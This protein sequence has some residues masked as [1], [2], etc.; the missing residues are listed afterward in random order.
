MGPSAVPSSLHRAH[1]A[2][3]LTSP[4]ARRRLPH[5]AAPQAGSARDDQQ[6]RLGVRPTLSRCPSNGVADPLPPSPSAGDERVRPSLSLPPARSLHYELRLT[7]SPR[8]RPLRQPAAEPV[9][10]DRPALTAA[11]AASRSTLC[12]SF[13]SD[14]FSRYLSA[15]LRQSLVVYSSIP[16]LWSTRSAAPLPLHRLDHPPRIARTRPSASLCS[17]VVLPFLH[18][19]SLSL[20][21]ALARPSVPCWPALVGRRRGGGRCSIMS[22]GLPRRFSPL[23]RDACARQ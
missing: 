4:H 2:R 21:P 13:P 7:R 8:R 6:D 17:P 9:A 10:A 3:Q 1:E 23:L 11:A 18:S 20:S 5:Q 22:K 15:S 14:P 16:S 12:P 19:L